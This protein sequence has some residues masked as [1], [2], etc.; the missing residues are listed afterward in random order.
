MKN[1]NKRILTSLLLFL[2]IYFS[3]KNLLI[4]FVTILLINFIVLSELKMI[5][6]KIFK[7]NHLNQSL[8]FFFFTTYMVFFSTLIWT[9]LLPEN[10]FS[11]ISLMLILMICISTDIGGYTFGKIIGGKTFTKISPKKTYS[12]IAGSF[13]F[14]YIVAT[15]FK[16]FFGNYLEIKM[17]FLLLILVISTVSQLGDLT[18]SFLKR[19]AN[20]KDTGSI[21]PG[22]GG[23]LD[24]IDGILFALPLGIILIS[25]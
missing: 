18:I 24:R 14:S 17:N 15:I 6:K 12:G 10:I 1:L 16:I 13:I 2:L 25:I 3:L 9:Y 21:L 5:L 11:T 23:I 20:I 4:L 22:H 19:K 7:K 8:S